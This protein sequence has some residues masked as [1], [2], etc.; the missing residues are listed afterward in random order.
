MKKY[1]FLLFLALFLVGAANGQ[2]GISGAYKTFAA[3]GWGDYFR[4]EFAEGPGTIPGYAVGV[5]YWFRLKKKRVEFLPELSYERYEKTLASGTAFDHRIYAFYFNTNIYPFDLENDC[6]CPTWSKTGNFFTKGFFVQLSPG[7]WQ[8]R[9]GYETDRR[10]EQDTF[11]W[12]LGGGLGLDLGV[13]DFLTV[14]PMVKM[15]WSPDNRWDN[16]P[17]V[18]NGTTNVSSSISQLYAGVKLG[19]QLQQGRTVRRR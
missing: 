6:D 10:H 12:V 13:S 8:L 5:N 16:L 3:N 17:E 15:Y 18:G 9:N 1:I 19:F 4:T 2:I 7:L 14:T 11:A